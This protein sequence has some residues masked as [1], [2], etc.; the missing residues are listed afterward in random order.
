MAKILKV[1]VN[2]PQDPKDLEEL[3]DKAMS[4]LA[5]SIIRKLPP[6]AVNELIKK[7]QNS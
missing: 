5:K 4:I 2:Y 6:Q 1:T 3:Q 7:L